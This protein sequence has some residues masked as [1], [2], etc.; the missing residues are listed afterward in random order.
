[1]VKN[2]KS[3]PSIKKPRTLDLEKGRAIVEK[4]IRENQ[5][6]LKEMAKK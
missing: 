1:M 3:K 5:E 6:W 4:V 2:A